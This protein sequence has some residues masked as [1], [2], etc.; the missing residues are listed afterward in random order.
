MNHFLADFCQNLLKTN[1]KSKLVLIVR[2]NAIFQST[3]S[4]SVYDNA[5]AFF[6]L[7]SFLS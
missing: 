5:V 1:P 7:V 6:E 2:K 4:L 3:Q